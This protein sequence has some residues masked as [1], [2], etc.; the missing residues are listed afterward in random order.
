MQEEAG[1]YPLAGKPTRPV[2][3][4]LLCRVPDEPRFALCRMSA[5]RNATVSESRNGVDSYQRVVRWWAARSGEIRAEIKR[6]KPPVR[7][8]RL[9]PPSGSQETTASGLLEGSSSAARGG[10]QLDSSPV[11]IAFG[12]QLVVRADFGD[13][14]LTEHNDAVGMVDGAQPVC[15]DEARATLHQSM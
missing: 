9:S 8:D 5:P 14:T 15:D 11:V 1:D 13:L 10:L 7:D 6:S 3:F 12:H 2:A 4:R